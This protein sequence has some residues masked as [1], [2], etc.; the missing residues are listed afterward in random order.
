MGKKKGK[1]KKNKTPKLTAEQ[2]QEQKRL[3]DEKLLADAQKEEERKKQEKSEVDQRRVR[4]VR[5]NELTTLEIEPNTLDIAAF[6]DLAESLR[7]NSSITHLSLAGNSTDE[8]IE[9]VAEALCFHDSL[10]SLDLK[11]SWVCPHEADVLSSVLENSMTLTN[12]DLGGNWLKDEGAVM[13]S[14]F[15]PFSNV[16]VLNLSNNWIALQGFAA[17]AG[18]LKMAQ[19]L[20]T[21]V[22]NG[23]KAGDEGAEMIAGVLE[24]NHVIKTLDI[25]DNQITSEGA[26][27]IAASIKANKTLMSLKMRS[28][29]LGD[30]GALAFADALADQWTL[31]SLDLGWNSIGDVGAGVLAHA[32]DGGIG[33][34]EQLV[35]GTTVAEPQWTRGGYRE[36]KV[37]EVRYGDEGSIYTVDFEDEKGKELS[38]WD[39]RQ[40]G[41][42]WLASGN[43]HAGAGDECGLR[44][45]GLE[46]NIIGNNGASLLA[47]ALHTNQVLLQLDMDFNHCGDEGADSFGLAIKVNPTLLSLSLSNN[48][49]RNKGAARLTNALKYGRAMKDFRFKGNFVHKTM[50]TALE[51]N[52]AHP[53]RDNPPPEP[54]D[55]AASQASSASSKNSKGSKKG[56]KAKKGKKKGGKKK[57]K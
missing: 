46:S 26:K 35:V 8:A 44:V 3:A 29:S 4:R 56:K 52:A 42:W 45:L 28:N 41:A 25:S 18:A 22:L 43:Q 57:K 27:F 10:T 55:D 33:W 12:L 9:V 38:F 54:H 53:L 40:L 17:I 32:L 31:T 7:N 48:R 51:W 30:N 19:A 24:D 5:N 34:E 11:N 20:D 14:S 23:N 21:V 16:S 49:V 13:L 37:V 50:E 1:G 36:G 47:L 2:I 6:G 15:L 39:M